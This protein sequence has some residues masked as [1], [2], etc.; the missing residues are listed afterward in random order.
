MT[1]SSSD[2]PKGEVMTLSSADRLK[3]EVMTPYKRVYRK[4][5]QP[6]VEITARNYDV[7]KDRIFPQ[8]REQQTQQRDASHRT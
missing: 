5:D 3:G 7:T 2:R 8:R 6:T 1:P 4:R